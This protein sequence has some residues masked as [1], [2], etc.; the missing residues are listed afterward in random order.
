[1]DAIV[2]LVDACDRNRFVESKAELD[3][4]LTDEQLAN[5]PV[6]IL[7]NKI[8]RPGAAS[9]DELR[10]VFALYGQTTG[11]VLL[12]LFD[13]KT[14]LTTFYKSQ[15]LPRCINYPEMTGNKFFPVIDCIGM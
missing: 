2:F 5:C 15:T 10:N 9:E 13:L 11:K 4:L 12:K 14:H 1:M 3:S 7:G 8:D 6:L